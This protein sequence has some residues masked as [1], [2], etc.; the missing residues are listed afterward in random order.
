MIERDRN[1]PATRSKLAVCSVHVALLTYKRPKLVAN[2]LDNLKIIDIP[3]FA[4]VSILVVDND[5]AQSAKSVV[6]KYVP[7]FGNLRYV[8]EP[9]RG[10]PVARNRAIDEAVAQNADLLCFIDDDEYPDKNWLASLLNCWKSERSHLV[11]G[12]VF[13]APASQRLNIWQRFVHSGLSKRASRK[14]RMT[15]RAASAGRRYTIVTNNWLCDIG[16]LKQSKV[17]FDERLLYSG[18]S[19][20]EFFRQAKA[21][22]C[23]YKWCPKAIVY[24]IIL[25]ERLSLRYQFHRAASQSMNHFNIKRKGSGPLAIAITLFTAGLRALSGATLMVFPVF[26]IASPIIG[27]R[28]IGWSFGRVKALLGRRSNLYE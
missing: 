19:D 3:E 7:D 1:I 5:E 11:G 20:T 14:M 10:I 9:R 25:P 8:A 21:A 17:R 15:A 27:V 24:E 6:E 4:A 23:Q 13:V 18:G 12:P 22:S 28:S 2:L 16:W 26:G